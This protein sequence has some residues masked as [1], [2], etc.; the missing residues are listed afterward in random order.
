MQTTVCFP[1]EYVSCAEGALFLWKTAL[2]METFSSGRWQLC[3]GAFSLH[4]SGLYH[5]NHGLFSSETPQSGRESPYPQES[6]INPS[7]G[8][9]FTSAIRDSLLLRAEGRP[10]PHITPQTALFSS[11]TVLPRPVPECSPPAS[12]VPR[13]RSDSPPAYM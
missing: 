5:T 11:Q 4:G 13:I 1:Q 10:P 7:K 6:G 2:E 9:P 12:S 3:R 8:V